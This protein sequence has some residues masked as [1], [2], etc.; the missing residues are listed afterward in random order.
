VE[1]LGVSA[2]VITVGPVRRTRDEA[3]AVAALCRERGWSRLVLVTSPV[4][5][6]RAAAAFEREGLSVFVSP[7]LETRFDWETLDR[8]DQRLEAFGAILHER[9]GLW[10]YAW[11]GWTGP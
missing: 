10:Y 3:V 6:R 7:S 4:H 9:V 8:P 11:R 5:T 2:D 1:R